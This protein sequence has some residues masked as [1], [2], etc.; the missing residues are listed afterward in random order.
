[1]TSAI[2]LIFCAFVVNLSCAQV[3]FEVNVA[4]ERMTVDFI[5]SHFLDEKSRW[6]LFNRDRGV[7]YYDERSNGFLTVNSIGYNFKSGFG[8][9][10][11]LIGDNTRVYPSVG[12]LYQKSFRSLFMYFLATYKLSNS[13]LQ[14]NYIFVVYKS[15]LREKITFIWHNEL[16]SSFLNWKNDVSMERVKFGI[17]FSLTEVGIINELYQSGEEYK[18]TL[19]NIGIYVKRTL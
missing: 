2:I 1:M 14:E 5:A 4:S 13:T 18:S 6:S 16:Y 7:F 3:S 11:N 17:E 15:R 10:A 9:A 8:F 19:T 12:A